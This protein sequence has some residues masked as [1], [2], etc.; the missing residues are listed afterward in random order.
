MRDVSDQKEAERKIKK[1]YQ[2]REQILDRIN[3]AFFAIDQNRN[4]TYWIKQAEEIAGVKRD[5]VIGN[6]IWEK[7]PKS[8]ERKFLVNSTGH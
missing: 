2:Q 5:E 4:V 1:A 6:N 7:F 3:E 8:M